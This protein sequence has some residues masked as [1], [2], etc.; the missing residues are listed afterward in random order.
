MRVGRR[1]TIHLASVRMTHKAALAPIALFLLAQ[2]AIAAN[3]PA[4]TA[5]TKA[6]ARL[7]QAIL[8]ND[9][10][11]VRSLVTA[12]WTIVDSDGHLIARDRFLQV[13]Q[14]GVLKHQ[15]M[16]TRDVQVRLY[17]NSAIVTGITST[18]GTYDGKPFTTEERSTDF[19]VMQH[20]RWFCAF[21]QLTAAR[22]H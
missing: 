3:L 21:T 6:E 10:T 4:Q 9:A 2:S 17:A 15:K 19:F 5:V 18:V 13:I 1:V 8:A 12:D 7:T 11:R 22:G 14:L 20:G 16:E